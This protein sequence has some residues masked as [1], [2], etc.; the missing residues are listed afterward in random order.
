M[1]IIFGVQQ[2]EGNVVVERQLLDIALATDRWARDGTFVRA[3]GRIGMGFQPYHTHQRSQLEA[4]PVV[5][6]LGNMLT[7]DGRIDNHKELCAELEMEDADASDSLI[8]LA[9]FRR[10]GEGC[11]VRFVGDW[12][13][14]IWSA[15]DRTLYLAR[16]HAGSRT[17]YFEIRNGH[18]YWA[19]FLESFF[20]EERTRKLDERYA[21]CYVACQPIRDLTPYAGITAVTPAHYVAIRENAVIRQQ[22]W[23]CI[24]SSRTTALRD[25]EFEEGF[26]FHFERAVRRC[27]SSTAPIIAH[28]SGG[29][30]SS[31]IVCMSDCV[32][33]ESGRS[34][35][36]YIDTVS[37]YDDSDPAWDETPYFTCIEEARGKRGIHIDVST[38]EWTLNL[39]PPKADALLPGSDSLLL[40]WDY[41]SMPSG[42]RDKYRVVVSGIG[43]DEILGGI[44]TGVPE[45]ADRLVCGQWLTLLRRG[46]AWS[47]PERQPLMHLL[48][49]LGQFAFGQYLP[50]G[51]DLAGSPGWL[52]AKTIRQ[53][54][55]NAIDASYVKPLTLARP[56][57]IS[58]SHAWWSVLE[59][60]PHRLQAPDGRYEYRY[61]Y[62]DR[63]FVEFIFQTPREQIVAP[64]RRRYLMRR[65]LASLVPGRVLE[66]RRKASLARSPILSLQ[67]TLRL[68]PSLLT[69]CYTVQCGL[70]NAALLEK[71]I[72]S[73]T[74]GS[75]I[76]DWHYLLRLIK[77]E[78]WIS[79]QYP[80]R[81]SGVDSR[82]WLQRVPLSYTR[83]KE[84]NVGGQAS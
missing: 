72:A 76:S 40:N 68:N 12:A 11:F 81:L 33:K 29:M 64:G 28:L 31:S 49:E 38:L 35:N 20:V 42:H 46:V 21:A 61:P 70:V 34:S 26:R 75:K 2:S 44:P 30:D 83:A 69:D 43:G 80:A 50:L 7:V 14:S 4:H 39:T 63:E 47:L 84:V 74:E 10:W 1:S 15:V 17:L 23:R 24:P 52:A 16:D 36:E 54:R 45:L 22:H 59:T 60:Q 13:L 56:S 6:Q 55:R 77:W 32:S 67:N 19:T 65:A 25:R 5:D 27:T 66:R 62:L 57:A 51:L 78:L 9:A 48:I 79:E 37:F 3:R 73:I 41:S 8:V 18:V 82:C 53:C 71:A 58:N